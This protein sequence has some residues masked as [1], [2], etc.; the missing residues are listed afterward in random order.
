MC[1]PSLVEIAPELCPGIHKHSF[2]Y[3]DFQLDDGRTTETCGSIRS[4]II[5]LILPHVS[6]VQVVKLTYDSDVA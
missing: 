5:L 6:V 2:L 3:I 4:K 1:V